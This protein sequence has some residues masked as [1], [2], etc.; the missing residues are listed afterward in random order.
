MLDVPGLAPVIQSP[1][2]L[3]EAL[4]QHVD[5]C[6]H[7]SGAAL[8]DT[9]PAVFERYRTAV[10]SARSQ[11]PIR[12]HSS[13]GSATSVNSGPAQDSGRRAIDPAR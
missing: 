9:P 5:S 3:P 11:W 7:R 12:A 4:H 8:R 13:A 6:L 10:E 1:S 2:T